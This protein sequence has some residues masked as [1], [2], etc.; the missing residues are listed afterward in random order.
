MWKYCL[1]KLAGWVVVLL[2]IRVSYFLVRIL[3]DISYVVSVQARRSVEGN[4]RQVLG[5]EVSNTI[6]NK[7][8]RSILR[9]CLKNYIDLMRI[10][11]LSCSYLSSHIIVHNRINLD[12]ALLKGKGAILFTAHL[13]SFD[14]AAQVLPMYFKNIIIPVEPLQPD[15]LFKY[16]CSLRENNGI[17]VV[18]A[19]NGAM[20]TLLGSL[21]NSNILLFACDR[22]FN[23]NGVKAA[24]FGKETIMPREAIRIAMITGAALVPIFN[25]RRDDG[26]I[27]IY[28][29]PAVEINRKG[30]T[31]VAQNLERTIVVMENYI[32][33]YPEQWVVLSPVWVN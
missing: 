10:P 2:P 31:A 15:I 32:R 30:D 33:K 11:V 13:G 17:S 3:A 28:I 1:Y 26:K 20:R 6:L 12:K 25:A 18:P 24:F 19:T 4:I 27:D 7:I 23:N 21:R 14:L 5:P 8:T 16:I 29:E 9:N 22:S